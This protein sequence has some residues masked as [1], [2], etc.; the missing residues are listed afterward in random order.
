MKKV[1][2][3]AFLDKVGKQYAKDKNAH[4]LNAAVAKT[5]LI[6]LAFVRQAAAKLDGEFEVEVK[7][8]GITAQKQSGRCWMFSVMNIMR[9]IVINKCNLESFELSGNYLAFYDKLEKANNCL[10]MYI[11]NAKKPLDDR[12]MEYC[13]EGIGDGGY[14]SMAVDLVNKYGIVPKY[15][16]P[17]TEQSTH[18]AKFMELLNNLLRKD[19]AVLRK[20]VKEKKDPYPEKEKM[21]AEIYKAL[22]IVFGEPVKEFD[23]SYR[24]KDNNFH[25]D[26]KMTP[27]SFYDKY[28]GMKLN[29]YITITNEPTDNKKLNK[30]YSFH[31]MGNMVES[32]VDYIN[33]PIEQ[34]KELAIKQLKDNDPVW[35]ACDAGAYGDRKMGVWD[36]DSVDFESLLGGVDMYLE[37]GERLMYN[38]SF[39]NH[40]MILTGV[41]FDK[42]GKPNRYKIENSWGDEVG[43]KGYFVCSDKYF[44]EYVYE[45]IINKKHLNAQQKKVLKMKPTVLRPWDK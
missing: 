25:Q 21:M 26:Y 43:K 11:E 6:D 37:K 36:Q 28:I 44:D 15:V 22:C 13:L 1:I 41:N 23:F 20:L 42:K 19:G 14:F 30:P 29:D 4:V 7:T 8:H 33:L 12:M 45:V 10:E 16:M 34:L 39:G 2:D 38:A 17:E 27:K 40:A 9:E 3:K 35:F 5:P 31:Y 24:D 32:N 18:T